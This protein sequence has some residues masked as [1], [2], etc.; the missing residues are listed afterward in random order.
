MTVERQV[1]A[2]LRIV[3]GHPAF[4]A[5]VPGSGAGGGGT[6]SPTNKD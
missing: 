2:A 4:P 5:S 3:R 1:E 6:P